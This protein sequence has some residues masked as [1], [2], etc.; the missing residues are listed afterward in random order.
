MDAFSRELN[1]MLVK[2]FWSVMKVEEQMLKQDPRLNLSISEFH[3]IESVG[4]A[5]E[6]GR[7]IGDIAL[8]LGIA[9]PP[10]TV[11]VN[12]LQEKG[13]VDKRRDDKDGRVVY[14]TL[15]EKGRKINALHTYFHTQMVREVNGLL[16]DEERDVLLRALSKLNVF[17]DR[18]VSQGAQA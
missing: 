11:S 5:D 14:V 12:K 13:Y 2:T 1:E 6:R 16:A 8:D 4:K 15:S 18:K 7:T 9:R 3:L 10:V 17:F